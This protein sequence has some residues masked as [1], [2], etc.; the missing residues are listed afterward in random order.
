MRILRFALGPMYA[1]YEKTLRR[2]ITNKHL[3]Q[4]I[5]IILDG[6]RRH[7][8]SIRIPL[9]LGYEMGS[10][11][12][13]EVLDWLWDFDIKVVS[14]WIFSTENFT[15]DADQISKIFE[16]AE[17]RTEKIRGDSKIHGRGV[18]VR[19]SGDL[20]RLPASLQKQ[21]DKTEEATEKYTNHILNIC[22]AYGGRQE[23][24]EAT[25]KIAKLVKDGHL[26]YDDI[27]EELITQHLYTNG[28]PDPDLI[29]RTS[30][31]ARLS[32]FLMWQ[33]AYSELF[34]TDVLWPNFRKIDLYRAIRDYQGR[35][36]NFGA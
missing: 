25:K 35:R 18:Q 17:Q 34:F 6:N 5:G 22:L 10:D 21:I 24:I 15:R 32:G 23:L 1:L 9:K 26:T 8:T 31:S 33:S 3:P 27:D 11:K 29:I 4:H 2:E 20:T 7:A 19:Y 13:E 12:L 36:R 16:I 14:V 28:L 30:G